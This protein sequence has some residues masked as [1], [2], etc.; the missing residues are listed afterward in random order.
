MTPSPL[1]TSHP[2]QSGFFPH[3]YAAPSQS[4][5]LNCYTPTR[6]FTR[7]PSARFSINKL[8]DDTW[9]LCIPVPIPKYAST[10][11]NG[12]STIQT[13]TILTT[14]K[15]PEVVVNENT[16]LDEAITVHTVHRSD[17]GLLLVWLTRHKRFV[18]PRLLQLNVTGEGT[19]LCEG[20]SNLA[21]E[22]RSERPKRRS[23]RLGKNRGWLERMKE[24]HGRR[25]N[26]LGKMSEKH[27]RR[28]AGSEDERKAREE[29]RQAREADRKAREKEQHSKEDEHSTINITAAAAPATADKNMQVHIKDRMAKLGLAACPSGYEFKKTNEGYQC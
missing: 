25:R 22:E 4:S 26:R 16:D 9:A 15:L 27:G 17:T 2:S 28:E 19:P 7:S 29:E 8:R 20:F 5:L 3:T 21:K 11:D 13:D 10:Y 12:N 1:L 23:E 14:K 6:H 24:R 18:S